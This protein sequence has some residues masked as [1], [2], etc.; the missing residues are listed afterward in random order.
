M[1]A[2]EGG[3]GKINFHG[4]LQG[5]ESFLGLGLRQCSIYVDA[6]IVLVVSCLIREREV[7]SIGFVDS[8][9]AGGQK[10]E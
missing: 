2:C 6:C 9:L 3:G 10:H 8:F 5:G 1:N 4:T 7:E